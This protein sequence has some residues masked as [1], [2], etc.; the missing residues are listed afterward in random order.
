M[1]TLETV[2]HDPSPCYPLFTEPDFYFC[3]LIPDLLSDRELQDL[4]DPQALLCR[5]DGIPAGLIV[6][7]LPDDGYRTHYGLQARFS[8]DCPLEDAVTAV[9]EAL[10][11]L[12]T[13]RP[14]HR[15]SHEVCEVDQR[16]I[17][18]AEAIGLQL[19]GTLPGALTV[20]GGH[21]GIRYYSKLFEETDA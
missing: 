8:R 2:G 9:Q 16:G 3:T 20:A 7:P 5:R 10:R 21:H 12:I 17:E 1:I 6:L 18:L 14:V 15:I 19:E 11:A 13:F 4:I